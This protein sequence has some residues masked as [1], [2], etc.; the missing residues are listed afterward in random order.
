[1]TMNNNSGDNY[2]GNEQLQGDLDTLRAATRSQTL[3]TR[4]Q[5]AEIPVVIGP[6]HQDKDWRHCVSKAMS[7]LLMVT[8]DPAGCQ[9]SGITTN[10]GPELPVPGTQ[11]LVGQPNVGAWGQTRI[12]SS[13]GSAASYELSGGCGDFPVDGYWLNGFFYPLDPSLFNTGDKFYIAPGGGSTG[14]GAAGGW[15][16]FDGQKFVSMDPQP[17]PPGPGG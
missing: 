8:Y 4:S 15:W 6:S 1:M 3:Q 7:N 17:D 16:Q 5:L 13:G 12:I 11:T 9:N 2:T 10:L 14:T